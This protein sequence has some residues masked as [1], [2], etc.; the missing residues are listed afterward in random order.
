[1]EKKGK[2]GGQ[3]GLKPSSI[4]FFS[5]PV[6]SKPCIGTT[7]GEHKKVHE[8]VF[9]TFEDFSKLYCTKRGAHVSDVHISSLAEDLIGLL[10]QGRIDLPKFEAEIAP[11]RELEE[12]ALSLQTASKLAKQE[13]KRQNN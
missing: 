7:A 4:D 3:V 13:T 5:P 12:K 9:L 11:L 1:M 8:C 10:T 2:D 6:S